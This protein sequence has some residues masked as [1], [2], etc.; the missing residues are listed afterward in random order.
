MEQVYCIEL[1][2]KECGQAPTNVPPNFVVF[3]NNNFLHTI[4]AHV[5]SKKVPISIDGATKTKINIS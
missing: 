2:I 3:D 5:E 1:I 4:K